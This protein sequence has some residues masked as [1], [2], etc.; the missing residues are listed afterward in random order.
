MSSKVIYIAEDDELLRNLYERKFTLSGY[1]IQTAKDGAEV[2][3]LIS[4]KAPDLL[5]LDINMPGVDGF[6]VLDKLTATERTFPI[7][8]LSN[9]ADDPHKEKAAGYKIERFLEKQHTTIKHL[10]EIAEEMIGSSK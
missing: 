10:L 7:L 5:V 4:K 1:S 9:F 6:Q 3:D 8:M 2:L